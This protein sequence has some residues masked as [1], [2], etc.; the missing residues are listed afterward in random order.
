V[1]ADNRR[2]GQL[3]RAQGFVD[4]GR[5]RGYYHHA[6]GQAVDALVLRRALQKADPAST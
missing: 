3:Y 4:A 1:A 5:R 2:R 6:R